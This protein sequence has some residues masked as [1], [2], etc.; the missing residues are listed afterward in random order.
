[1]FENIPDSTKRL[2]VYISNKIQLDESTE[3][4]KSLAY[5]LMEHI[6]KIERTDIILDRS[7]NITNGQKKQLEEALKRLNNNEPIQYIIGET[8]FYGRSFK[9]N[10]SVLIP[11]G[12]T[13]ELVQLII[14]ENSGRKIRILDIGTGS[15][16]IP[17]SLAKELKGSRV[18]AIDYDPRAIKVAR[19]NAELHNVSVDY[20]L[21]D[22]LNEPIPVTG[23]DVIVSN[24][25]YVMDS[26]K[27][28]MKEN[29]LQ[30]EPATA[31]FVR[32]DDPLIY[33]RRIAELAKSSLKEHGNLYFEI[34]ERFGEDIRAMLEVMDYSNVEIL[35]DLNGKDRMARATNSIPILS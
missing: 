26:E 19:K 6:F 20:F 15:G 29:V 22:I 10:N 9:I 12:E 2:L 8:E 23:L 5:L 18:Y 25:P 1:M 17:V 27:T 11:R 34:N 33:Y 7:V 35:K 31:L 13:E 16:C 24:P 4:V 3:E 30:Y 32:D 14:K 21:I 28:D